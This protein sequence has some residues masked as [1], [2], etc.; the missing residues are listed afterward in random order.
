MSGSFFEIN[1]SKRFIR[2]I[3]EE[4]SFLEIKNWGEP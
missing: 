4:R 1:I 2:Y 3:I